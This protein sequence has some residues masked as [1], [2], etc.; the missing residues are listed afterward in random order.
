VK[1]ISTDKLEMTSQNHSYTVLE[2]SLKDTGLKITHIN[3][4]DQTIEGLSDESKRIFSVQ[5]NPE[6]A[7]GPQDSLYLFDQF[8]NIMETEVRTHA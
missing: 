5:Y 2:S 8:I 6:S 1:N 3:V 4:L 7:P